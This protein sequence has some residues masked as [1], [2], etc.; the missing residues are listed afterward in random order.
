[1]HTPF[2]HLKFGV[3]LLAFVFSPAVL[4]A[5][6]AP[7][8]FVKLSTGQVASGTT[9]TSA[10]TTTIA[11]PGAG[12]I[13]S[14]A[15]PVSGNTWN[16]I[17]RPNPSIGSNNTSTV[18]QYVCNSANAIALADASG[19]ATSVRLT[20]SLDIQDLENNTTRTE[21]NTAAGG[22]TVLGPAGLMQQAWRIYRGGNGT[23]HRLTGLPAGANYHLYAYGSTTSTGQGC[24]FI[25]EAANVPGGNGTATQFLEIRGGNSGNLYQ[26]DGTNYSLSAPAP[27]NLASTAAD[28]NSWGRIHVVVDGN[29]ALGFR[30]AKNAANSQYYQGYQLMPYPIAVFTTQPMAASSATVGGSVTI[31]AAV[32][33]EGTL[34]YRWTKGG[35][36]ITDGVSGT[37]SSYSG[38]TTL[39]LTLAD[40]TSAD[41]GEY[42]VVV[43]NP[44]GSATSAASTLSITTGAISPSIATNPVS[45]TGVVDGAVSFTVSANGTAPLAFL[46]QKSL[47]NVDFAD[48]SSAN[49]STLGLSP[50]TTA[51]AGYYRVVISNSVGSITSS[52]ASLTVAPA[53][54]AVPA[55][56]IVAAGASHTL[57]VVADAGAGSPAPIT[58]VWK[59]AGVNVANS[60]N[61]TGAD[62]ASLVLSGFLAAQSGYYTVTVSNAAGSYTSPPVYVGTATAQATSLAPASGSINV[63]I[64]SPLVI[65]F[66][67]PPR[68]GS[69]GKIT[70]RRASDDAIV[71]TIDL[72][73]LPTVINGAAT[74]RYKSRVIGDN[75]YRYLPVAVVGDEIRVTLQSATALAY[76]VSYY[77]T[78][79]AGAVLDSTGASLAPLAGAAGWTFSTKAA[80]PQAVPAR[81]TFSVA[82]DGSGDFS[83]VQAALDHVPAGNTTPVRLDIKAGVYDGIIHSGTRHNL[84]L[85]GEGSERTIIQSLNNDLFNPGTSGR[86][87][88]T[89]KGNDLLVRDLALVNTTPKGGSQAESLRS[90]GQRVIFLGC[91]FRSFQ[92]TLLLGGTSHF[93]D[94]LIAGDTDYIWGGGTALFKNCE[95]LCLNAAELTQSRA[96][97]NKFGFVFLD[98]SLTKPAGSSFS[99]GLGRNSDNSNVAFIDCRMDTHISAAGWSTG[100]GRILRNWEYNSKN[101]AGTSLI[102]V[103]AR[104][105][106][107]QLTATEADILRIPANVFGTT[108]DGTP[109]GALGDGW[110]PVLPAS[111][112]PVIVTEPASR[113]VAAGQSVTFTVSATGAASLTYQWRK[114]GTPIPNEA[115]A[116]LTLTSVSFEAA[117]NYDCVVTNTGG[118]T[119]SAAAVL[120]VL[121]PVQFWA[122]GYGLDSAAPGFSTADSDGDGVANLLEYVLG[123]DPTVPESGLTPSVLTVEEAGGRYLVIDYI[124]ATAAA[125]VSTVIETSTDLA[126]W[127][128]RTPG[129]DAEVEVIPFIGT[130]LNVDVNSSA[131]D[132]YAGLAVAPGAGTVW[133]S[134]LTTAP[135]MA[136]L[137]DSSGAVTTMG[138]TVTSP[139]GFSAWSNTV[140]GTP[141]PPGLMQDYLFNNAYTVTLSGLPAG[142]YQ[143][144]VYARGDQDNQTSTITLAGANGGGVKS[145]ALAGTGPFR[146]AFATGAEGVAYVKFN[147]TVSATGTLQFTAANYLNGFQLVRIV[148]PA[149]ERVRVTIPF[150]GERLFARLR[151]SE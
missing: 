132:H 45:A 72:A 128:A 40:V 70:V 136:N 34:T 130:G 107:R 109:A 18:G 131:A 94:C 27:A 103:S 151:A 95:L 81:T 121:A 47:N 30:T 102:N 73:A 43:T 143:L 46:W 4:P 41:A 79:E 76:G 28:N 50:L 33:G 52:S 35:V 14:A 75:T 80:A 118:S 111:I 25:V 90:D 60:A 98:C 101:L 69:A 99:Y 106:G 57:S 20:L 37:G 39:A 8:I 5:Q 141:N 92:D 58:Y 144:I 32:T 55:A 145:T 67:A 31:T 23:L 49:T 149:H 129:L 13:Y 36:P 53:V 10:A 64:D 63:N 134:F 125:A 2:R 115:G 116:S 38:A 56:A 127:T 11:A 140:N 6:A 82:A 1:M 97:A 48:I 87:G 9:P 26:T 113:S 78:M 24:K 88:V 84:T 124:R 15:A 137:L 135:T 85:A 112:T 89:L 105:N 59:R 93:Q 3:S 61:V 114:G 51:D 117:G 100:F 12:W 148:D 83:T 123:G 42:A 77:V 19:A 119:I 65:R 147:L 146:D 126:V 133:N 71:E 16:Q 7:A 91:A 142:A 62:S 96:P 86:A 21:P 138:L 104:V 44:G 68:V 139:G 120:I 54:S 29:G 66:S 74:Y 122:S 17:L 108:S 150:A 22:S 110:T